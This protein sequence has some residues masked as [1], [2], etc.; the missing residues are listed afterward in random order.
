MANDWTIDQTV[1][2]WVKGDR[3]ATITA[4]ENT[5]INTRLCKL[6]EERPDDVV[7]KNEVLFQVP[8]SWV[9]INPPKELTDE[10]RQELADR[11]RNLRNDK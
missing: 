10:R 9:K 8:A 6:A 1:I 2:Y 5:R 7:K 4:P 11:L 3:I